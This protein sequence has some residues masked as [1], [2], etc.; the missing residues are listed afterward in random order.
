MSKPG[1]A[2]TPYTA[3]VAAVL[4][5]I[6]RVVR[7]LSTDLRSGRGI[8][9]SA[10]LKDVH[11]AVRGL[12]TELDLS[13]D[14]PWSRQVTAIRAE[15]SKLVSTEINLMLGRVRRLMRPRP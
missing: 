8:A 6:A 12:R 5:E 9:V 15:I 7:E 11:D 14:S 4:A 3:A 1:S 2:E 13:G 10:L